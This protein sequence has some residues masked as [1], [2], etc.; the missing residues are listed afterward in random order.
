MLGDDFDVE[1]E[2]EATQMGGLSGTQEP[3]GQDE[4]E[5]G[6]DSLQE[7]SEDEED[8][9]EEDSSDDVAN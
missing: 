8:K 3:R 7:E 4:Q 6:P 5:E 1:A 2:V 9:D